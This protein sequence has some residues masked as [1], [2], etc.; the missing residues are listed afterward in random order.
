V[1]PAY[2]FERGACGAGIPALLDPLHYARKAVLAM[3][4]G[5]RDDAVG[6]IAQAST[7]PSFFRNFNVIAF[8]LAFCPCPL[9][10]LGWLACANDAASDQQQAGW[11]GVTAH[12]AAVIRE[13][14]MGES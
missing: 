4:H 1:T 14:Q 13:S 8:I 11:S 7:I 10:Q 9:K 5:N 3:I 12:I 2:E 6:L